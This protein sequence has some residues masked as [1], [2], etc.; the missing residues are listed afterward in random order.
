[1]SSS[2]FKSEIECAKSTGPDCLFVSDPTQA[3]KQSAAMRDMV[4]KT[5]EDIN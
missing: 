2:G 5:C 3:D 4:R 1:M